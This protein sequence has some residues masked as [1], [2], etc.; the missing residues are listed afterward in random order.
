MSIDHKPDDGEER[1]RIEGAGGSVQDGRVEGN[2]NLSRALGDHNFKQVRRIVWWLAVLFASLI[3]W[4]G[5][6]TVSCVASATGNWVAGSHDSLW[7]VM[8]E[9]G[10]ASRETDDNRAARCQDYCL[11]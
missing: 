10:A 8:P 7:D 1:R 5:A 3:A 4:V 6:D 9:R 11:R 2:L